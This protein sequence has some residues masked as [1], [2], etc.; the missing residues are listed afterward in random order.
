MTP[1]FE[2]GKYQP[3][4]QVTVAALADIGYEVDM[5]AADPWIPANI[6]S[7]SDDRIVDTRVPAPSATF[8]LNEQNIIH[9]VMMTLQFSS[10]LLYIKAAHSIFDSFN[11]N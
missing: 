6:N 8:A 1:L 5:L 11:Y 7:I 10:I 4:S 9:P 3:L 2:K